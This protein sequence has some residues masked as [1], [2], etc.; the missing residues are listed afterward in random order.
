MDSEQ[1]AFYSGGEQSNADQS[2]QAS[3]HYTTKASTENGEDGRNE[4][5]GDPTDIPWRK[6][7]TAGMSRAQV[8]IAWSEAAA[9]RAGVPLNRPGQ[10]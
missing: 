8:K 10:G 2:S 9:D 1:F 5:E 7:V 3:T 4:P 6:P